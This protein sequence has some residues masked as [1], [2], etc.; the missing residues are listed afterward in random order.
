MK[1]KKNA[2]EL[3]KSSASTRREFNAGLAV[4]LGIIAC[5]PLPRRSRP[6]LDRGRW[7]LNERDS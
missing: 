4:L 5:A 2:R 7:I 1:S 6:R 3:G